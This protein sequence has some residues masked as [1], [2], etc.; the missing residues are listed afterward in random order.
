MASTD[1]RSEVWVATAL[2]TRKDSWEA[3]LL[4]PPSGDEEPPKRNPAGRAPIISLMLWI[5]PTRAWASGTVR[6]LGWTGKVHVNSASR[7]PSLRDSERT[8]ASSE[9]TNGGGGGRLSKTLNG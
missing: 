1:P 6:P 8:V 3:V 5:F 2:S 7:S 4:G 9:I